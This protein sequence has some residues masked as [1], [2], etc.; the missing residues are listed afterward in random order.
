M[1]SSELCGSWP[2]GYGGGGARGL[3]ARRGR[4]GRVSAA[5]GDPGLIRVN[6]V[7]L[8]TCSGGMNG[9]SRA[10]TPVGGV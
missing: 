8:V 10:T 5:E 9:G 4:G 1:N 7:V 2:A 6:G 3:A